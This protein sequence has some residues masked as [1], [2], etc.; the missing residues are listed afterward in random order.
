MNRKEFY[1]LL[2]LVR[3]QLSDDCINDHTLFFLVHF[4]PFFGYCYYNQDLKN[5]LEKM[6]NEK[7]IYRD[8]LKPK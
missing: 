5:K 1:S 2:S 3:K 4:S 7:V 8:T 6:D